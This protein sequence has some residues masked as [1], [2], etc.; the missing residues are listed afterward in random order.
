MKYVRLLSSLFDN[1]ENDQVV[2]KLAEGHGA[3]KLW[4]CESGFDPGSIGL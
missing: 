4:I 3:G 1:K 2:K